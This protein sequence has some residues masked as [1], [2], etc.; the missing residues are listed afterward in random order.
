M[1]IS[2]TMAIDK[3]ISIVQDI[4]IEDSPTWSKQI[5]FQNHLHIPLVL[6]F[7]GIYEDHVKLACELRERLQCWPQHYLMALADVREFLQA[8]AEPLLQVR[9]DLQRHNL[10]SGAALHHCCG[11]KANKHAH[12]KD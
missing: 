5:S 2:C 6:R 7:V 4:V 11:T 12:F 10:R 8:V 1:T 3:R 9:I